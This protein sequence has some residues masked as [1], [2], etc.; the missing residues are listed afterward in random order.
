MQ[1]DLLELRSYQ[2]KE[3]SPE[4][5]ARLRNGN[6]VTEW[7]DRIDGAYKFPV[8]AVTQSQNGSTEKNI[9]MVYVFRF[10]GEWRVGTYQMSLHS[11]TDEERNKLELYRAAEKAI[12]A[13]DEEDKQTTSST[14]DSKKEIPVPDFVG[15]KYDLAESMAKSI[16]LVLEK[17]EVDDEA[18]EGTVLSQDVAASDM[19]AA[20]S[21]IAVK[22]SRS[23]LNA[24]T[25]RVIFSIP[26]GVKGKF[27]IVL[28]QNDMP[29]FTGAS[30]DPEYAAGVTS[31]TVEGT[32]SADMM[33]V[34]ENDEVGVSANIG[35][36]HIDFDKQTVEMLN[37]D[38]DEAFRLTDSR[39]TGP[40]GAAN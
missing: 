37:V 40:Q 28:Y 18:A 5:A 25:V 9:E 34:L 35:M 17:Q 13:L 3:L 23:H 1:A 27:H 39:R 15:M 8:T 33:A 32:G 26:A 14:T 4:D 11:L 22:V 30:F 12:S 6:A 29:A 20:G 31:L 2:I 10:D 16:G 19:I 24:N 7:G 21:V 38:T 36:I